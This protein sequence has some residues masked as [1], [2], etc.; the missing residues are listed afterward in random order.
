MSRYAR[1]GARIARF[2]KRHQPVRRHAPWNTV[3]FGRSDLR[4]RRFGSLDGRR[5]DGSNRNQSEQR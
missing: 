2:Q 4:Q 5:Q 3:L 1:I